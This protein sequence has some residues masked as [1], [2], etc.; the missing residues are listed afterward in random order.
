MFEM[1]CI[2]LILGFF[3]SCSTINIWKFEHYLIRDLE[4][5]VIKTKDEYHGAYEEQHEKGLLLWFAISKV[6]KNCIGHRRF[7]FQIGFQIC[8]KCNMIVDFQY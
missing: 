6:Q 2:L 4:W 3:F 8:R 5:N 1:K 7:T